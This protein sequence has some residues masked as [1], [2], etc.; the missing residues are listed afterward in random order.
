VAGLDQVAMNNAAIIVGVGVR[1]GLP[2]RALVVAIA[3]ALQE[4]R[5]Y[6]YASGNV[7]ES[8]RYPHQAV[9]Y[10]HDSV[11]L[12]QQRPSQGW[13][14]VA[15]LMNPAYAAGLFYDRLVRVAGWESMS[16]AAAAQAVQVSAFPSA[17]E[18]HRNR[19]EQIV[20]ALT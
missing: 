17:Y 14:A 4:S 5:L 2:R 15:Q 16:V 9:G 20:G 13:G 1:R 19:A 7:P 11:G 12:F 6:N 10:D 3:T 8:L 18:Q